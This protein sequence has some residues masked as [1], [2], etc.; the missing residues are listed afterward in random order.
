[1]PALLSEQVV[2]GLRDI[3]RAYMPGNLW[4][5]SQDYPAVVDEHLITLE[6]IP[7][8]N[9]YIASELDPLPL[10]AMFVVAQEDSFPKDL[11]QGERQTCLVDVTVSVESVMGAQVLKLKTMRYARAAWMTFHD[12]GTTRGRG[13]YSFIVLADMVRYGPPAPSSSGRGF[14]MEAL[15]KLRVLHYEAWN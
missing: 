15:L 7:P 9:Y 12:Y 11:Q 8:N 13:D 5:V 10:P 4:R 3:A 6:P 14:E 1:M 2:R